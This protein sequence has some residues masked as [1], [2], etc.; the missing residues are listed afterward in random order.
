MIRVGVTDYVHAPFDIEE[1]AFPTAEFVVASPD[2]LGELDALLVWHALIDEDF[3]RQLENCRVVVRYGVGYENVDIGKLHSRSIPFANTPDY[4]IQ[5]VAD[6]ACSMILNLC[7]RTLEYDDAARSFRTGWQENILRPTARSSEMTVGVVGTGRIGTA[8]IERLK[9]FGFRLLGYDPFVPSGYEKAI[10]FTRIETLSDLLGA[11]DIV[12]LH[13]PENEETHG[14]VDNIFLA[15]MKPG[16][17][18]INT[19][20]G[21]LLEGLTPL[22]QALRS[23]HLRAAALDVLPDE[24]PDPGHPLIAAW[25]SREDWLRGRLIINPH[26]AYYSES[27][28]RDMRF[29]AAETIRIFLETGTVRNRVL[30]CSSTPSSSNV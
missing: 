23:G 25:S 19:A 4:G 7:R 3:I 1:E 14:M 16:A 20:R 9:P 13:C 29:K 30:S 2:V 22:E 24:P 21:G 26:S 10:G 17:A 18:L 12:T 11:A 6:S 8:L 5:E 28:W 15:Q 27:A